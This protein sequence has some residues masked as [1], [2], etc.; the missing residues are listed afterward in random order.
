MAL[1]VKIGLEIHCQLTQLNTKLFCACYS[2][3]R[4]KEINSNI[5]PVCIGLPGSLPILNKKAVE[6]AIMI[7]KALNCKI[8]EITVF[9]RKNYFYPDLPK[10]F[11]ITQ[12]DSNGTNTS[13]GKDGVVRYGENN[14]IARIRRIQLE[15]D[16]GRLIY[17]SGRMQAL[18]DY[19]RA[20]V[21]LVEI[22][23]EPDFTHPK[24]VRIFLNKMTSILEH[25]AVCNT[26]LEGSVRCDA[27]ISI[28]NGKK[29]EI[30]NV[31][32]F[33]D[34]EKALT[35]EITRQQT[36]NLHDIEIK[37]ETRHWDDKR[38]TTKQ[39]R[40]KEE[41]EDYRYFPEP[42][43]P[44]ILLEDTYLSLI[45]MPELPD[46]RKSRFIDNYGLSEHVAQ[47]LID[48]KELADLF[49]SA[50]KI[51]HSP[52]SISNWIVSD[53][54]AF[55]EYDVS[56]KKTL[57]DEIK[58]DAKHI[59]EIAKLVDDNTINR[60]T[61][62][63]IISRIIKTGELPS[64]II[65]K[66]KQKIT[67]I[68]DEKILLESIDKIFEEEKKAVLDAKQNPTAINFLLGKIMK[69][70]KGRADPKITTVLLKEKL[71]EIK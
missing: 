11:Q 13:I 3:Y 17:E 65:K 51:Y 70:T 37:A 48:N 61:A 46:E 4:E 26:N 66:E 6:F 64:D 52:K 32:S 57:T 55:I 39:A 58:I 7:S 59:A 33:S 40:S 2:N 15:E 69:F 35:Y 63:S 68:N 20:G 31:G 9:S 47:V 19:N 53:I 30:K 1:P 8:P 60:P 50:I 18:I 25:L 21:A 44:K 22:V 5:C 45:K 67:T 29:V 42:D 34:I 62:K 10:N 49:E 12:Y 71:N 38:K 16:P 28:G 27:N 36:M 56:G 23:T 24:D 43:I 14:K 54:L 41:E